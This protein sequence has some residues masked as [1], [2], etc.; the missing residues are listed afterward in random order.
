MLER[1]SQSVVLGGK[2]KM[3]FA[4]VQYRRFAFLLAA[5]ALLLFIQPINVSAEEEDGG[6]VYVLG[7]QSSGNTVIV[8][9][10]ATDGTLTRVQEV[11]IHGLGSG[12]T[13]DPLGSQGALVLGDGGHL[14]LAVNAGSN[15]LSVLS[16]TEDRVRFTDKI[17]SGGER[18]VSGTTHGD[19]VY[20]LNAGGTPN[21]TGFV[22]GRSDKLRASPHSTRPL[23]GGKTAAPAEAQFRPEGGLLLRTG[24]GT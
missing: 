6:A 11:D 2:E 3:H 17:S 19:L 9:H 22:V 12:G 20:V 18:P 14:L 10:R 21:I 5:V 4:I 15:E 24:K 1:L 16:V 8:F 7:N 13:N 23:P